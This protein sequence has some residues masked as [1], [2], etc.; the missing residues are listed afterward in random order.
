MRSHTHLTTMLI[1]VVALAICPMTVAYSQGNPIASPDSERFKQE[2]TRKIAEGVD[3]AKSS[4]DL[5]TVKENYW[6]LGSGRDRERLVNAYVR[7]KTEEIKEKDKLDP[8]RA[9]LK[10]VEEARSRF[11]DISELSEPKISFRSYPNPLLKV[12]WKGGLY[13]FDVSLDEKSFPL[14]EEGTADFSIHASVLG[15]R[16]RQNVTISPAK[17]EYLDHTQIGNLKSCKNGLRCLEATLVFAE[18]DSN[19]IEIE[20]TKEVLVRYHVIDRSQKRRAEGIL[21]KKFSPKTFS[22]HHSLS[23]ERE[24]DRDKFDKKYQPRS[25]DGSLEKF[26]SEEVSLPI[27]DVL[28][29]FI[30]SK[31]PY[32]LF[33]EK[34]PNE[35]SKSFE[36]ISEEIS[37][38][39]SDDQERAIT[40]MD[41]R[42]SNTAN[43][44]AKKTTS[45]S[46]RQSV[47]YVSHTFKDEKTQEEKAPQ[48]TG[49]YI[50]T[51]LV[52]TNHH[53]I[54][55][56]RI[57]NLLQS[58]GNDTYLGAVIG[59]DKRRDLALVQVYEGKSISKNHIM[60]LYTGDIDILSEVLAYGYPMGLGLSASRG[61]VS[62]LTTVLSRMPPVRLIQT[63]AAINKGNSGGPLIFHGKVIGVNS[64]A[65]RDN[66]AQDFTYVG[67][68]FA[69]HYDEIHAFL[70]QQGVGGGSIAECLN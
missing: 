14:A 63:D 66:H 17:R 65:L 54:E 53:V 32:E 26:E 61:I 62:S 18:Y 11:D 41:S 24:R 39:L 64:R 25:S 56:S 37:E 55:G 47:V 15:A 30:E 43:A 16:V 58:N 2:V 46:P 40:C 49:F 50:N 21:L 35:P 27:W 31:E 52:L 23:E 9:T 13:E 10:A 6:T 38:K 57:V 4:S 34:E 67:L 12:W 28:N 48:G 51:N 70:T 8:L 44:A 7:M 42:N 69:V 36:E 5:L 19:R 22:F 45:G 68:N 3:K 1:T 20:A 33:T 29:N 60:D 59:Y